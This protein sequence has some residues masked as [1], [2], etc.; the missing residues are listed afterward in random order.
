MEM[1][2]HLTSKA[3]PIVIVG[4][5]VF[6][7]STAL[8]LAEN[9]YSNVKILDKQAYDDSQYSYDK[10]CD[11]ASAGTWRSHLPQELASHFHG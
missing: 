11:A 9:G 3:S 1:T 6:G 2:S 8:H 5:G 7:I 10:G 4:A